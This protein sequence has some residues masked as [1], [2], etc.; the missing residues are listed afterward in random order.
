MIL[1]LIASKCIY[2]SVPFVPALAY[3]LN[4]QKKTFEEYKKDEEKIAN[5]EVIEDKGRGVEHDDIPLIEKLKL[6]REE[7]IHYSGNYVDSEY[8]PKIK[9]RNDRYDRY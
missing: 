5:N 6:L 9:K 7:L 4:L 3:T 1:G 2:F 8:K